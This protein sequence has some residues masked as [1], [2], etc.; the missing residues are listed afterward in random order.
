MPHS[1]TK[2]ILFESSEEA[3]KFLED[4]L[5]VLNVKVNDLGDIYGLSEDIGEQ[6]KE[7]KKPLPY[8]FFKTICDHTDLTMDDYS[9]KIV[10][11]HLDQCP[12]CETPSA[13]A[14]SLF[15]HKCGNRF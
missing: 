11:L 12:L 8:R 5:R 1:G 9:Y 6:I 15:C 2:G 13:S 14:D 3:S 4:V 10:P 7:N